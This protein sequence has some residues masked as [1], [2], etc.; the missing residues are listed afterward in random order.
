MELR[1]PPWRIADSE[2][3]RAHLLRDAPI[4]LAFV[5]GPPPAGLA[6]VL[7]IYDENQREVLL[8]GIDGDDLV[9]RHGY[10]A[11]ALRLDAGDV[12]WGDALAGA[13]AGDTVAVALASHRNAYCLS[14]DGQRRC[15]AGMTV[16]DT[17]MLLYYMSSLPI[18]VRAALA[19]LWP[20]A[21]LLATHLLLGAGGSVASAALVTIG[22]W[23]GPLA[24]GFPATPW[25]QL[26]PFALASVALAAYRRRRTSTRA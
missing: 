15:G 23:A 13:K 16:G 9:Y 21:A 14:L 22:L 11:R 5:A 7:S 10:A 4:E 6:P 19:A 26:V 25:W 2:D 20:S 8:L 1:G 3:L 17:W 24:L 18:G 12:R